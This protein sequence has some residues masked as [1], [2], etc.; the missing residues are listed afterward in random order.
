MNPQMTV[1][2]MSQQT[3]RTRLDQKA[4][5]GWLAQEAAKHCDNQ[6][7]RSNVIRCLGR[8]CGRLVQQ[9]IGGMAESARTSDEAIVP[10]R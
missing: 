2:Y 10:Y 4:Y 7:T 1:T 9:L 3:N 8:Q 6:A 5:Q